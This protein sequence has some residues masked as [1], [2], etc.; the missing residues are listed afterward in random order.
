MINIYV[1]FKSLHVALT[2]TYQQGKTYS[3]A[4]SG[5]HRNLLMSITGFAQVFKVLDNR[6][7]YNSL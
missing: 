2:Y 4:F 1:E 6:T 5:C 7:L 3:V